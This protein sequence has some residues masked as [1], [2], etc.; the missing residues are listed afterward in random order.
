MFHYVPFNLFSY[1]KFKF[2]FIIVYLRGELKIYMTLFLCETIK[3]VIT[4]HPQ[5]H[6]RGGGEII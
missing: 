4:L 6:P 3:S 1:I 2:N 5:A